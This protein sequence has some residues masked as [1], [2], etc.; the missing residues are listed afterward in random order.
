MCSQPPLHDAGIPKTPTRRTIQSQVFA[1]LKI[2]FDMPARAN[3]LDHLW[4]G[5]S[6]RGKN[7]VVRFLVGISQAATNEQPMAPI[8]FPSMQHGH[9]RPVEEPGAFASLTH[10]EALP[11]VGSKQEHFHLCCFHPPATPIRSHYPDWFIASTSHH[12]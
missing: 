3:G 11:I 7:E 1:P 8:I 4:Q 12:E 10:R 5:G 6:L 9:I 2:L